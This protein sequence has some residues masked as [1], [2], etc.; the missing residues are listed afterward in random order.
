MRVNVS[1]VEALSTQVLMFYL[2]AGL[3]RQIPET[4][5]H[6]LPYHQV[7]TFKKTK[8][9]MIESKIPE[10]FSVYHQQNEN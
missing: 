10:Q 6:F 8:T 7:T 5:W 4:H 2:N 3:Y 9:G 1:E